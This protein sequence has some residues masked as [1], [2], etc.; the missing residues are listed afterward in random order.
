MPYSKSIYLCTNVLF[1]YSPSITKDKLFF[2][3]KLVLFGIDIFP[4]GSE[5]LFL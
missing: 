5:E 4:Q 2:A 3:D 1:L